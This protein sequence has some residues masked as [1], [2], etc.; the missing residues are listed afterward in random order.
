MSLVLVT[1]GVLKIYLSLNENGNL[2]TSPVEQFLCMDGLE[3]AFPSYYRLFKHSLLFQS[4]FKGRN[5]LRKRV[6]SVIRKYPAL[7]GNLVVCLVS[8]S[9]RQRVWRLKGV[10]V[11]VCYLR[12]FRWKLIFSLGKVIW[13]KPSMCRE[14]HK[15]LFMRKRKGRANKNLKANLTD[16]IWCIHN[17]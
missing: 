11:T 8:L 7:T 4:L 6:S 5:A 17:W 3:A 13:K 2:T 16:F 10:S 14:E 1:P 15:D 9:Q 12:L